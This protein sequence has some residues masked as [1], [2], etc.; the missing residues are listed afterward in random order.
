M[1]YIIIRRA[2]LDDAPVIAD[3]TNQ[4]GYES[5]V[6]QSEKRLTKVLDSKNHVVFLAC[7]PDTEVV[8]WIHIFLAFRVESDC[9]AEIG[10]LVV[11]SAYRNRGFGKSLIAAAEEWSK[12]NRITKLRVRSRSQRSDALAFYEG[13]G[14]SKTKRQEV[15]DKSLD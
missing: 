1:S 6:E 14:F 10:G 2:A 7:L 3:L 12:K 5:T 13:L 11:S 8:G 9:F 4:L 15:L